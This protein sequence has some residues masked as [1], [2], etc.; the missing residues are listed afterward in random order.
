M[1]F[2]NIAGCIGKTTEG[3]RRLETDADFIA[4]LLEEQHVAAVSWRCLRH[5]PVFFG[6]PTR[7]IP[8]P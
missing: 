2:P 8:K 5:E 4:A 7:P 3:G 1:S 6:F